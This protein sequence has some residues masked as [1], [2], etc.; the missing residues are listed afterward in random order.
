LETDFSLKIYFLAW[1]LYLWHIRKKISNWFNGTT[2]KH[3]K[4]LISPS[5]LF[6]FHKLPSISC[7]VFKLIDWKHPGP[8]TLLKSPYFIKSFCLI[9][10]LKHRK[11]VRKFMIESLQYV[12]SWII[13]FFTASYRFRTLELNRIKQCP[14]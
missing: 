13:I 11:M 1:T 7:I 4:M 6:T 2:T 5:N 3:Y 9:T 12:K 10:K 8:I 14:F